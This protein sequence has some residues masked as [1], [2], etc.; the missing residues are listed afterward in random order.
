[1]LNG[2]KSLLE[3]FMIKSYNEYLSFNLANLKF[4]LT[5]TETF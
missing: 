5:Q 1:M 2:I 3:Q 4:D